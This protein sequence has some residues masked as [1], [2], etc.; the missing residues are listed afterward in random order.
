MLAATRITI[1][2]GETN[3]VSGFERFDKKVILPNFSSISP[4]LNRSLTLYFVWFSWIRWRELNDER[5]KIKGIPFVNGLTW[6][7]LKM[8]EHFCFTAT[9][10]HFRRFA[11]CWFQY[12]L[13]LSVWCLFSRAC[14]SG[15]M[16]LANCFRNWTTPGKSVRIFDRIIAIQ[17]YIMKSRIE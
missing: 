16:R 9:Y 2:S 11:Y 7:C 12:I 1:H 4:T 6:V 14:S 13:I 10:L 17:N 5:P 15:F 8:N 3:K